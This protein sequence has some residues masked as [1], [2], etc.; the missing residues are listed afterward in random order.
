MTMATKS[1]YKDPS[2]GADA[3]RQFNNVLLAKSTQCIIQRIHDIR[4]LSMYMRADVFVTTKL[5]RTLP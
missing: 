2:L 1:S 5:A 4:N 3:R